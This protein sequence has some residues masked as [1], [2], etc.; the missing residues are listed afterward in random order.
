MAE[1]IFRK[2]EHNKNNLASNLNER[3]CVKEMKENCP[4]LAM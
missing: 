3:N 4:L 1:N 2:Y